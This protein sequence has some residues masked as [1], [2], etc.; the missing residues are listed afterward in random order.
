MFSIQS[1]K[2][3]FAQLTQSKSDV[4]QQMI[5]GL[6]SIHNGKNY[7]FFWSVGS[8]LSM[9]FECKFFSVNGNV[10]SSVGHYMMYQ[11]AMTFGDQVNAVQLLH[12]KSAKKIIKHGSRIKNINEE[13]WNKK[14]QQIIYSATLSKFTQNKK[15]EEVLVRTK[16]HT[17]VE[18]GS[19]NKI[20][21]IGYKA[22]DALNHIDDWGLNLNGKS[23][24][25]ARDVLNCRR[26]FGKHYK[27]LLS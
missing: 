26:H 18:V 11:K 10:F 9:W 20:S 27:L 4:T 2:K 8:P 17:L 7:H 22:H 13:I 6:T 19:Y 25:R 12:A 24:M 23:L 14:R 16:N 1:K 21:G 15:L 5:D 3:T